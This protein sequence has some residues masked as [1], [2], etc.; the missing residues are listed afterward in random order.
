MSAVERA[1]LGCILIDSELLEGARAQQLRSEHFGD[2]RHQSVY[3]A[4]CRLKDHGQ[5]IDVLT[6]RSVFSTEERLED[7]GGIGYLASLDVDI[8]DVNHFDTYVL[9]V[10]SDS[11]KRLSGS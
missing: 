10:K 5:A 6:L 8:P 1:V 3:K 4:M 7:V 11:V 2:P 9:Q